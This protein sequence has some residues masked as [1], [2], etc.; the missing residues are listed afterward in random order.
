MKNLQQLIIEAI[1]R[2][3]RRQQAMIKVIAKQKP[4]SVCEASNIRFRVANN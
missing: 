1:R 4:F 2:D 3:L